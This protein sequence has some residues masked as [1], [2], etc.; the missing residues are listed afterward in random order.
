MFFVLV[1]ELRTVCVLSVIKGKFVLG[2][3][4]F[5]CSFRQSNVEFAVC[6]VACGHMF[7]VDDACC[8]TVVA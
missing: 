5:K 7:L 2:E 6:V 4:L 1:F 8:K 3:T